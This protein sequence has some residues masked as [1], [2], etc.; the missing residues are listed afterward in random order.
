MSKPQIHFVI[1]APRSGSTW[2]AKTLNHHPDVFVTE[3]RFFGNFF[4]VWP[5]NNGSPA[6]RITLDAF[7]QALS[8]HY[9]HQHLAKSRDEFI[10]DFIGRYAQF[11]LEFAHQKTGKSVIIDKITP[12]PGTSRSVINKIK[13][14]FPDSKIIQLVRDGRDVAT[15][16]TFD[17]LQKD[18]AGTNRHQYFVENQRTDGL[19]RFFDDDALTS[20]SQNWKETVQVFRNNKPALRISYESMLT[21]Q[22]SEI[23]KILELVGA[24]VSDELIDEYCQLE[25]FQAAT[26]RPNGQMDPLA[27][28]RSGVAG[29]WVRFMTRKDGELFDKIAG[30]ALIDEGYESDANW[31]DD[32]PEKLELN[33]S[34]GIS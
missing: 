28:Q 9:F 14:H 23:K 32:L 13:L 31:I 18:A 15:S 6:P 24:Q 20:W 30:K 5:N 1:S 3:H 25:S 19:T 34:D 11:M 4:E 7:A 22:A 2:L 12:Y 33:I 27:K 26:G 21:D 16:G 17:W 8:V 29:D 10:D